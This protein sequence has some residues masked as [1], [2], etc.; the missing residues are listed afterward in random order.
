MTHKLIPSPGVSKILGYFFESLLPFAKRRNILS[1]SCPDD[2]SLRS[3]EDGREHLESR[4]SFEKLTGVHSKWSSDDGSLRSCGRD[5]T[6]F[7]IAC[8]VRK[9]QSTNVQS[10]KSTPISFTKLSFPQNLLSF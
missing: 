10:Q 1:K 2:E 4:L 7:G 5:A 6:V 9:R 3:Q 8:V